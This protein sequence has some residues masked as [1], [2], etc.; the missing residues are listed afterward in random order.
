M[1]GVVNRDTIRKPSY[2]ILFETEY[3]PVCG[4]ENTYQE[5]IFDE[6]KPERYEDRHIWHEWH[7]GCVI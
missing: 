6:P 1:D 2:W 4:Y 7:C 3:C 5:R